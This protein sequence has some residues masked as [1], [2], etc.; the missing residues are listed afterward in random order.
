MPQY[1]QWSKGITM[2]IFS[3][4]FLPGLHSVLSS[5]S[6]FLGLVD[7]AGQTG[8]LSRRAPRVE[9]QS[10][11][12]VCLSADRDRGVNPVLDPRDDPTVSV[13]RYYVD[14]HILHR[15]PCSAPGALAGARSVVVHRSGRR[16]RL[17]VSYVFLVCSF[18]AVP[19]S[20][21]A[22]IFVILP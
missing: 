6:P 21:T 16:I 19:P 18:S 17:C 1:P 3:S 5:H 9:H 10:H 2:S 14:T 8:V 7:P 22:L 13:R 12:A 11:L 15:S 4:W 20:S